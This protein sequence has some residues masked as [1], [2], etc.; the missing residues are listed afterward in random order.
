MRLFALTHAY[1]YVLCV[2]YLW[3][4]SHMHNIN[5]IYNIHIS[6]S[7]TLRIGRCFKKKKWR[8]IFCFISYNICDICVSYTIF[9]MCTAYIVY[10][11][12][13]AGT[14]G[15][16]TP[17]PST[18]ILNIWFILYMLTSYAQEILYIQYI[19]FYLLD[20]SK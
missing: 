6:T 15:V 11:F 10:I 4:I 7:W 14:F 17:T 12:L 2:L 18:Y 8:I 9:C 13:P 16:E 20:P 1:P 5:N 19:Y 3:Y